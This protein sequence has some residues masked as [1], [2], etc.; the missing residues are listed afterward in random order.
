MVGFRAGL[1]VSEKKCDLVRTFFSEF[2]LFFSFYF[3]STCVF[4][5]IIITSPFTF[6]VQH[7]TQTCMPAAGFILVFSCTL[8]FIRSCFF[9]SIVLHFAFRLCLQHTTQTFKAPAGFETATP[10]HDWPET[11]GHWDRQD[12]NHGPSSPK[13]SSYTE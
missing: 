1:D 9:V 7:T 3:L 4:V 13:P 10:A 11:L 2:L 12:S 5:L 8:Y 6:T